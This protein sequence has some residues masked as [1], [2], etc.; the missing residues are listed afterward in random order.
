MKW[1]DLLLNIDGVLYFADSHLASFDLK[2]VDAPN[3]DLIGYSESLQFL[4]IRFSTG[5]RFI[6][7]EVPKEIFDNIST[8]KSIGSFMVEKV[9]GYFRY[10][11]IDYW[12]EKASPTEICKHW[13]N[14]QYNL[15]T[16]LG[17]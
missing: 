7:K 3:I 4:L 8:A 6:Y 13:R 2:F 9:K 16:T 1:N 12:I 17:N 14:M 11:E 10:E 15:N 5:K